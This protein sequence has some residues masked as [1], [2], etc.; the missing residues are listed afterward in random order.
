MNEKI[1][2]LEKRVRELEGLRNQLLGMSTFAKYGFRM[3]VLIAGWGGIDLLRKFAAWLN[4]PMNV[5][6]PH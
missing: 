1:N 3:L 4:A 2:D 6:R 5:G